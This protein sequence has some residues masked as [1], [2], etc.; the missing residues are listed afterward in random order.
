MGDVQQLAVVCG[1]GSLH[2]LEM[3]ELGAADRLVERIGQLAAE[4]NSPFFRWM[5]AN[6]RCCRL[7][8]SGSGDE[9]EQAALKALQIG[10]DAGQPDLLTWFVPQLFVARWS[11]GRAAELV[12]RIRQVTADTPGV[13]A[14]RAG[15]AIACAQL[16][17]RDEAVSIV[18]DLMVDPSTAF[19]DNV[20]WLLGHSVLAE[21]VAAVGTAEQAA[22]EYPLLAPYAGRVPCLGNVARPAISLSLAVL[23]VRAG[24][25][26]RAEQHFAD[27]HDQHHRLGATA[28]LARTQLE[29]ASCLIHAGEPERARALFVRARDSA[30]QM[31][32]A[33]VAAAAEALLVDVAETREEGV[34]T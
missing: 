17:E 25:P 32:V 33:D 28:W 22:R 26:E 14:W 31:G 4:V 9:I 34:E 1:G 2:C 21:A 30:K 5:E 13:P 23:A 18:D 24:W 11:Q 10:Q 16:G 27:A 3:G 15:L 7:T 8:V 6:H 19:P 20:V 29:W 12:D